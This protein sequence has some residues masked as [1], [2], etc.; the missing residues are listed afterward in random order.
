MLGDDGRE[1]IIEY[2]VAAKIIDFIIKSTLKL[3]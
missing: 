3:A 1:I 2:K